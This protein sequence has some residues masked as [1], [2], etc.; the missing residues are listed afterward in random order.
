[1]VGFQGR[2]FADITF[3]YIVPWHIDF[4]A[5]SDHEYKNIIIFLVT[6]T[7]IILSVKLITRFVDEL[8][9]CLD[10]VY[11]EKDLFYDSNV[12]HTMASLR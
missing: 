10:F 12:Q 4:M 2:F 5:K 8:S 3:S 9:Y 1:M 11:T 7:S 6:V